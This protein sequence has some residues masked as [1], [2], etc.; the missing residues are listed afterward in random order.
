MFMNQNKGQQAQ[1]SS[2]TK[3]LKQAY[4]TINVSIVIV[5]MEFHVYSL[6]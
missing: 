2:L 1:F 6:Y 4:T 5:I 3:T